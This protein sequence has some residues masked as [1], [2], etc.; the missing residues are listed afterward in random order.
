MGRCLLTKGLD[1]L[2]RSLVCDGKA[3][4]KGVFQLDREYLYHFARY[5]NDNDRFRSMHLPCINSCNP[6]TTLRSHES[7]PLLQ[8]KGRTHGEL[9][10]L[11]K[12]TPVGKKVPFLMVGR[13]VGI[14]RTFCT[15][16]EQLLSLWCQAGQTFPHAQQPILTHECAFQEH[17]AP[18]S[19]T[20]PPVAASPVVW[21]TRSLAE[22]IS[23]E[24]T[25]CCL[26]ASLPGPADS[27]FAVPCKS[28]NLAFPAP[29]SAHA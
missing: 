4:T 18:L 5:R 19:L 16:P 26:P 12:F 27:W 6:Q 10:N 29:A 8:L 1:W 17:T 21:P 7:I 25:L 22:V 14:E 3:K 13:A 15:G 9:G 28:W 20:F 11:L 24:H 23:Q 2:S